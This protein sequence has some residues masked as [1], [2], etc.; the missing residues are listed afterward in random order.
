M[1]AHVNGGFEEYGA[2]KRKA[3]SMSARAKQAPEQHVVHK[4]LYTARVSDDGDGIPRV[5]MRAWFVP[6]KQ[7]ALFV[8][9]CA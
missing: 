1:N 9:V 2:S 7:T 5:S 8:V 4:V 6:N 3:N